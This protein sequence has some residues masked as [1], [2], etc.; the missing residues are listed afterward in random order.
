[1]KGKLIIIESGADAS[2]KATQTNKLYERL[3]QEEKKEKK[4]LFRTMT[5]ILQLWLKCT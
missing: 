2:G 4:L 5:A 1:M 3:V